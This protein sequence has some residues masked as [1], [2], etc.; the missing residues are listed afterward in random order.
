MDVV[1]VVVLWLFLLVLIF[2]FFGTSQEIGWEEHLQ[3][4]LFC[5]E[6]DVKP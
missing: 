2:V 3:N 5:V 4:E 6:W 1:V